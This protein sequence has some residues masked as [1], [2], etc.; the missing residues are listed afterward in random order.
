[1]SFGIGGTTNRLKSINVDQYYKARHAQETNTYAKACRDKIL[2]EVMNQDPIFKKGNKILELSPRFK[3]FYD[4]F[5][6]PL[7][8]NVLDELLISGIVAVTFTKVPVHTINGKTDFEIVP[9]VLNHGLGL[10]YN[11][12]VYNDPEV[13]GSTSF[14]F[15]KQVDKNGN[16]LNATPDPNVIIMHGF[17]HVP[18]GNGNL[19]SPASTVIEDTDNMA[20]LTRFRMQ[21]EANRSNPTIFT[22]TTQTSQGVLKPNDFYL[23]Y[24]DVGAVK[25]SEKS[26]TMKN[27]QEVQQMYEQQANT[28]MQQNETLQSFQHQFNQAHNVNGTTYEKQ[29]YNNF[30][31]LPVD[32]VI[33]NPKLPEAPR[34][35]EQLNRVYQQNIC[36]AYGVPR[37]L[38]VNDTQR[39]ESGV[40]EVAKTFSQ[41]VERFKRSL[42]Y[43]LT[44]LYDFIY[45]DI[46]EAQ[47][48]LFRY[49]NQNLGMNV[50]DQSTLSSNNMF[51]MS[52]VNR[53]IQKIVDIKRNRDKMLGYNNGTQK[54]NYNISS[55]D[56]MKLFLAG[57]RLLVNQSIIDDKYNPNIRNN[58][59]DH[60]YGK[61]SE[62]TIFNNYGRNS[63]ETTQ[64]GIDMIDEAVIL[65]RFKK[66]SKNPDFANADIISQ[67][68]MLNN[69]ERE[70]INKK[71]ESKYD[72][73][74]SSRFKFNSDLILKGE[75]NEPEKIKIE[76]S[77][78]II[79]SMENYVTLY[80]M[81]ILPWSNFADT[82]LRASGIDPKTI[83][84]P[85]K[86]PNG[87]L[88]KFTL[89]SPYLQQQTPESDKEKNDIN[90]NDNK[91]IEN[92]A[93]S[94]TVT[95]EKTTE[96][97]E[98]NTVTRTT[99]VT[100]ENSQTNNGN[101]GGG[102]SS[103]K[104]NDTN[105]PSPSSSS[106]APSSESKKRKE[107]PNNTSKDSNKDDKNKSDNDS[108]SSDNKKNKKQKTK[109]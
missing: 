31:P 26:K 24:D 108:S 49:L 94:K 38:L 55:H 5:W 39:G 96:D 101:D 53:V 4:D 11:I 28:L 47:L 109:K 68:E 65:D 86:D 41:T 83:N 23:Y 69:E 95:T 10:D 67:I 77:K 61:Q 58:P 1:M 15:K 76:F 78:S 52:S 59:G 12:Y 54:D 36:S 75:G 80:A 20:L 42:S 72:S 88:P 104:K 19:R 102:Q 92:R 32:H 70:R 84:I 18:D 37:N 45:G 9:K 82:A 56:A 66:K 2:S 79:S 81:N 91:P 74:H 98:T 30:F 64:N 14:V 35:W 87:P 107:S 43:I 22:Q 73:N 51:N 17:E 48:L 57:G 89:I 97:P 85:K 29:Y 46:D 50:Q 63:F 13:V 33:A 93:K 99:T 60:F 106:S 3:Q 21:A 27:A 6:V 62:V 100:S 105:I 34:D 40:Q 7:T 71:K 8:I 44:Q 103:N 25:E 16:L 90:K